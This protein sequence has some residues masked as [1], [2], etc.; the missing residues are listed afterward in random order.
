MVCSGRFVFLLFGLCFMRFSVYCVNVKAY[1]FL[2]LS[3]S[4]RQKHKPSSQDDYRTGSRLIIFVLGGVCY[5][6][7]R[8]A[9]EVTQASKSCEVIIGQYLFIVGHD[10]SGDGLM[11]GFGGDASCFSAQSADS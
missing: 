8:C 1:I 2:C 11:S 6:E 10:N 7:M 5:S 4:A 9:Y 3:L